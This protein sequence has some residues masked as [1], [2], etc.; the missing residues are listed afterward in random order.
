ML[1]DSSIWGSKDY[2]DPSSLLFDAPTMFKI[3]SFKELL[4]WVP[5]SD[6]DDEVCQ[7]LPYDCGS[8]FE[9]DPEWSDFH[10]HFE[11]LLLISGFSAIVLRVYSVNTMMGKD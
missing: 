8:W 11:I 10:D 5:W 3:H 2:P 1:D 7:D 9:G 6:L 4:W